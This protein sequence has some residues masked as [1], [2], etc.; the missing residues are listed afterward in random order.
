[1]THEHKQRLWQQHV[2]QWQ[3]SQL[4]QREYCQQH[5]LALATFGYWRKR[6]SIAKTPENKLIPVVR[7][8]EPL[9]R[10]TL[11]GGIQIEAPAHVLPDLLSLVMKHMKESG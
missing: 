4:S 9:I 7:S 6:L 8:A 1:M 3:T 2:A 11:A 10:I 5:N